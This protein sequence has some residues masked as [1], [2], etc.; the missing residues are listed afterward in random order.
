ML[1]VFKAPGTKVFSARFTIHFPWLRTMTD[2]SVGVLEP[3]PAP[4]TH[5]GARSIGS[6]L[7]GSL[8]D[9]QEMS[10]SDTLQQAHFFPQIILLVCVLTLSGS[11]HRDVH[12]G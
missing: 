2:L 12:T 4:H 11:K 6:L 1:L 7:A 9:W 8:G 3:H 10:S 5:G